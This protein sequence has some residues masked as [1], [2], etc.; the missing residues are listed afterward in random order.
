M[1]PHDELASTRYCLANPGSEYLVFQPGGHGYFTVNLSDAKGSLA[2]E[3]FNV[4][5]DRMLPGETVE[6]GGRR[7]FRT[8]FPGPAALYLKRTGGVR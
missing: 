3:W 2:V 7:L 8:P 5:A 6:G 4:N 1:S